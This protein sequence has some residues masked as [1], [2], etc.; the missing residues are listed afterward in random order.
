MY[1]YYMNTSIYIKNELYETNV[2]SKGFISPCSNYFKELTAMK[3]GMINGLILYLE[4]SNYYWSL[5]VVVFV[6]HDNLACE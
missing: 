6:L 2:K 3:C 5:L 1:M 4:I